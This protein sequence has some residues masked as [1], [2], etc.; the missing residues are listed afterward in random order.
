MAPGNDRNK[1]MSGIY[2]IE[3][4]TEEEA[5]DFIDKYSGCPVW[6]T[7][8]VVLTAITALPFNNPCQSC[9]AYYSI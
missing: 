6:P 4:K 3:F 2:L 8:P 1:Y 5:D 7:F 9:P